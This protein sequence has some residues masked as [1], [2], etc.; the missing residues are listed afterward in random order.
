MLLDADGGKFYFI[1]FLILKCVMVIFNAHR[2][3]IHFFNQKK[4]IFNAHTMSFIVCG[5][6]ILDFPGIIAV[7][8]N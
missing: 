6:E 7:L 1:L 3:S 8:K 4:I 2:P 5:L